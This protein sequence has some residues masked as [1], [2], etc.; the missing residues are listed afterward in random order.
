MGGRYRWL[1]PDERARIAARLCERGP[2]RELALEFGCSTRTV[3][4]IGEH[5]ALVRGRVAQSPHRLSF[6]ERERISRGIAAGEND[7]GR[8]TDT[9]KPRPGKFRPSRSQP[10]TA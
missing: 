5:A 10:E 4:R 9:P 7:S 3:Q 6:V 8:S 1:R 2:V